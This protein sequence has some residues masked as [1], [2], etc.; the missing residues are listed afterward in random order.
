M[1]SEKKKIL[2]VV[3]PTASGKTSLSLSLAEALDGENISCDSMQIYRDMNIGTA[4]KKYA[5]ANCMD[6]TKKADKEENW[7]KKYELLESQIRTKVESMI[8]EVKESVR[9][10][11]GD[12]CEDLGGLWYS[13]GATQPT[14]NDAKDLTVFYATVSGRGA[15][16]ATI[17]TWG[18]CYQNSEKLMCEAYNDDAPD[19]EVF[20]SWN[21]ATETCEFSSGWYEYMCERALGGYYDTDMC[22]IPNE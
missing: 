5:I 15:Q 21:S 18:Y 8:S 13:A 20:T 22:Y 19:D 1:N 16:D 9:D 17:G 12:I 3:G 11:L 14:G 7:D 10:S 6:P 4:I 2:A